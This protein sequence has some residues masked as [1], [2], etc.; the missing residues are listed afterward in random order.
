M[1]YLGGSPIDRRISELYWNPITKPL[2]SSMAKKAPFGG[3]G[4]GLS[5]LKYDFDGSLYVI[6]HVEVE[7]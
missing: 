3:H 1:N 7:C 4:F 6:M 2:D 5:Y